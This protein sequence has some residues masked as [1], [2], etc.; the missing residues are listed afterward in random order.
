MDIKIIGVIG[1]AAVLCYRLYTAY[2]SYVHQRKEKTEFSNRGFKSMK[3][4]IG[5][6]QKYSLELPVHMEKVY[7]L[8]DA[9][10]LQ[11]QNEEKE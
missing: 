3:G 7:D 9:A 11:L 1:A 2:K 5:I 10:S 8:N 4:T 6:P